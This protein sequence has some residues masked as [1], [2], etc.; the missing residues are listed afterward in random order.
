[1]K[2]LDEEEALASVTRTVTAYAERGPYFLN[3]DEVVVRNILLGLARNLVEYSY[4]YCPCRQVQGIPEKDFKNI[5]PCK[6]HKK[7]I[8]Q[9]G[10]CECGLFVSKAYLKRRNTKRDAKQY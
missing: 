9:T 8:A 4:A 10:S 1:M 5:C 7:E 3:P 2:K 6:T